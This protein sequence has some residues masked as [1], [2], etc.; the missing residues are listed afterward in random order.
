MSFFQEGLIF[1]FYF[2]FFITAALGRLEFS[3]C[4]ARIG[5][6]RC[7][8]RTQQFRHFPNGAPRRN[9]TSNLWVR[10]PT[11]YPLNYGRVAERTKLEIFMSQPRFPLSGI[12]W[13]R[14]QD[15]NLCVLFRTIAFEAIAL[16]RSATPPFVSANR[17]ILRV[18]QFILNPARRGEVRPRR[19]S[20]TYSPA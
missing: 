9:R 12:T 8:R 17:R 20:N 11:L 14:R 10:N 7:E 1:A 19:D 15:S 6:R 16:S 4:G 5:R 3:L 2:I 18:N 13:R